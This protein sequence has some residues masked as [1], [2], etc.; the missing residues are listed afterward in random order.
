L[1]SETRGIINS[2]QAD[3][4]GILAEAE[5][6]SQCLLKQGVA[7]I[8][9]KAKTTQQVGVEVHKGDEVSVTKTGV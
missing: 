8:S 7:G 9:L 5:A 1:A 2:L 3:I 6:T 4:G